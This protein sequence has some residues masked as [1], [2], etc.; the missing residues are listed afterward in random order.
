MKNAL[1]LSLVLGLPWF[2]G[3]YTVQWASKVYPVFLKKG[4][5]FSARYFH[6]WAL[7]EVHFWIFNFLQFAIDGKNNSKTKVE[8]VFFF[9]LMSSYAE[10]R[11]L[12]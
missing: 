8:K 6:T 11:F 12:K 3:K 5:T 2:I 4:C 7:G 9:I 10:M 1:L